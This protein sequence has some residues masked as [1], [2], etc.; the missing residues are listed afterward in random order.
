MINLQIMHLRMFFFC[1]LLYSE[2]TTSIVQS[3]PLACNQ[4]KEQLCT[5]ML[6]H[7]LQICLV[8]PKKQTREALTQRYDQKKNMTESTACHQVAYMHNRF[9]WATI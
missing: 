3:Q 5:C 4:T 9:T 2:H 7:I 6:I 1:F 8:Q